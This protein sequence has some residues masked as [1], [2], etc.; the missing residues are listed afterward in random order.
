MIPPSRYR[1]LILVMA[2]L[3]AFA[4][5]KWPHAAA[6]FRAL[7]ATSPSPPALSP[8][9]PSLSNVTTTGAGPISPTP[10][11]RGLPTSHWRTPLDGP[12]IIGRGFE[13]PVTPYGPGHRGVDL[14]STAGAQVRAAA[15]GTVS[16]AGM[17]AGRGVIT[18]NHGSL[19]T[20]YEPVTPVVPAGRP[21]ASG[22]IIGRLA[23]GHPGCP[24]DACLHWGLLDGSLYRN[25]LSL[26]PRRHP[27]LLPVG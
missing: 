7:A 17:I 13:P 3:A 10:A 27:R 20:T 18:I 16:F 15:S 24:A 19:R 11:V 1:A 21:V 14:V 22:E 4:V 5:T 25:P 9:S 8:P 12:L 23:G 6:D 2:V 26:L